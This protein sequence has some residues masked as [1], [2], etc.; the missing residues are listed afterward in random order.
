M[1]V[2]FVPL[3]NLVTEDEYADETGGYGMPRSKLF[4][5]ETERPFSRSYR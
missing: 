3:D 1:T 4:L 2:D 5:K